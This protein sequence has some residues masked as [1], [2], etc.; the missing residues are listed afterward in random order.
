[1]AK[2]TAIKSEPERR[3]MDYWRGFIRFFGCLVRLLQAQ[4]DI[5]PPQYSWNCA[6]SGQ[7]SMK[8]DAD[9]PI[10]KGL[11][12]ENPD[13]FASPPLCPGGKT[14]INAGSH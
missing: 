11:V 4:T 12:A 2:L 9:F 1:M 7:G 3:N 10:R 13:F 8:L 6:H 5:D 14:E